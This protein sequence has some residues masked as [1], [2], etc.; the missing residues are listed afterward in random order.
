MDKTN[1]VPAALEPAA[2]IPCIP[3]LITGDNTGIVPRATFLIVCAAGRCAR[4]RFR[5]LFRVTGKEARRVH[6]TCSR[7]VPICREVRLQQICLAPRHRKQYKQRACNECKEFR[8][9]GE[10]RCTEVND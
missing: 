4:I 6:T 10:D 7:W 1:L 8:R 5:A 3:Q 2:E 9:H